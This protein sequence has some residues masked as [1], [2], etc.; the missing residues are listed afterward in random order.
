[1]PRRKPAPQASDSL[2]RS[3]AGAAARLMAEDGIYDYGTAKRKAARNLGASSGEALPTNEEIGDELR[4][5]Q[6]LYQEDEQRERLRFMR[7]VA[8]DVMGL[9]DDFRPYLTGAVLDGTAARFAEIELELFADSAKDVEISLLSRDIPYEPADKG[10]VQSHAAHLPEA[11]LRLDWDGI[12]VLLSIY[13]LTAERHQKRGSH[14]GRSQ[15]R[16]RSA[17]VEALLA[18]TA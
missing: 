3:I 2:R 17:A 9:L 4:A 18:A 7:G 1:M 16:A 8:L 6:S 12:P 10:G 5:Y 11:R 13:P 15:P 14:N